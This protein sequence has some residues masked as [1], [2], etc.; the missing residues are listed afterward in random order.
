MTLRESGT[1]SYAESRYEVFVRQ[2]FAF[3]L[4]SYGGLQRLLTM[5][6]GRKVFATAVAEMRAGTLTATE[7]VLL[8]PNGYVEKAEKEQ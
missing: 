8:G 2:Q 4:E 6:E 5:E 1:T 7:V 3:A